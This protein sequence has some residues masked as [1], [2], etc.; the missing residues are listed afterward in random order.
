METLSRRSRSAK[1]KSQDSLEKSHPAWGKA[2]RL[3]TSSSSPSA[4]VQVQG[5]VFPSPTEVPR[6]TGAQPRFAF[7]IKAKDSSGR[8]AEPP[9]EVMPISVWSPP[10]QSAEPP[11]SIAEDLGRKHPEADGDED[12]LLSNAE[13][14]AARSH[15]SSGILISRGRVPCLLRRSWLYPSRG[16]PL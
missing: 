12:S 4:H 15:L 3:G 16:S 8:A 14:A 5:Q 1:H 2:P 6:A 7:S 13:L 11:P 10:T 9:L